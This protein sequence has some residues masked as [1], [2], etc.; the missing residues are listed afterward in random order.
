MRW[1]AHLLSLRDKLVPLS[2]NELQAFLFDHENQV[3]LSDVI[4]VT[5]LDAIERSD[6]AYLNESTW[7]HLCQ[8]LDVIIKILNHQASNYKVERK[9]EVIISDSRLKDNAPFQLSQKLGKKADLIFLLQ[10]FQFLRSSLNQVKTVN[11]RRNLLGILAFAFSK[12][13]C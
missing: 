6:S 1:T 3:K 5:A 9:R 12:Y 13:S 11:E 8:T 2:M 4:A 7:I 10:C